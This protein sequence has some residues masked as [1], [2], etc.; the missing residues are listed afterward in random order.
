MVNNLRGSQQGRW[1]KSVV[2]DIFDGARQGWEVWAGRE[3]TKS[4]GIRLIPKWGNNPFLV[5]HAW[6]SPRNV[7]FRS[8]YTLADYATLSL[9]HRAKFMYISEASLFLL[10]AIE[11]NVHIPQRIMS[12]AD[13][14]RIYFECRCRRRRCGMLF[15]TDLPP[16]PRPT[17]SQV[18]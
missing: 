13:S 14:G 4:Q 7:L 3:A 15:R 16:N 12:M 2:R 5:Y 9:V 10:W 1:F 8:V 18:Y 11:T 17:P 6:S